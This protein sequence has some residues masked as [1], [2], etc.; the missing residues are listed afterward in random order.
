[1]VTRSPRPHPGISPFAANGSGAGFRLHGVRDRFP[2]HEKTRKKTAFVCAKAAK[3]NFPGY[4]RTAGMNR[5]SVPHPS[6]IG[7]D[8][9]HVPSLAEPWCT[10]MSRSSGL[11]LIV[12]PTFPDILQWHVWSDSSLTAAG[13]RGVFTQLPFS[14][15]VVAG[16]LIDVD[17]QLSG[18][19]QWCRPSMEPE[20]FQSFMGRVSSMSRKNPGHAGWSHRWPCGHY[21]HR[22]GVRQVHSPHCTKS[23]QRCTESCHAVLSR[24][25]HK[26][27]QP[28]GIP[29]VKYR[30]IEIC[31]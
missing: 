10:S 28:H 25:G 11:S 29:I 3:R 20:R 2:R 23:Y 24:L 19:S 30:A 26:R 12:L 16:E 9:L 7:Y 1:M 4:S 27:P 14:S 13:P 18:S 6:G 21:T 17:M 5:P 15:P 31:V 22:P 8:R